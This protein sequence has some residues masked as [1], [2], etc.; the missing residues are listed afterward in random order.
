MQE[1]I[2]WKRPWCWEKMRAGGEGRVTE[3]AMVGWHH[4][5]NGHE[6]E[7]TLGDSEGPGRLACCSSWG[8]R[9]L[10]MTL[11]TEQ[12][13]V[14]SSMCLS[15]SVWKEITSPS[16]FLGS[17]CSLC[18]RIDR[19]FA[20]HFYHCDG[21]RRMEDSTALDWTTDGGTWHESSFH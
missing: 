8:R 5:L 4:P 16:L 10:D 18:S 21:P 13:L 11:A 19:C 15:N 17:S 7:Q 1:L 12:Q 3:N 6:F 2:H 14:L 9:E 20:C